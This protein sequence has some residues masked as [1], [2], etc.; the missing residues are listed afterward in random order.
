M[1][2]LGCEAVIAVGIRFA[3]P[4]L[5]KVFDFA[6]RAN[7]SLGLVRSLTRTPLVDFLAQHRRSSRTRV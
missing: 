1:A 4:Y 7:P 5:H 2:L 3:D 6:L